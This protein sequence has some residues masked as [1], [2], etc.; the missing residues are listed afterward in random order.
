MIGIA[1]GIP[2]SGQALPQWTPAQRALYAWFRMDPEYVS[3][4]SGDVAALTDLSG[5]ARDLAQTTA[6][7]RLDYSASDA[8]FNNRPVL[9][10]TGA[11]SLVRSGSAW[12]LVQ[13][14]TVYV[15]WRSGATGDFR[16]AL[17]HV[18]NPRALVR[19]EPAG[20]AQTYAN[21]SILTSTES[22]TS[23]SIVCA[24][25]N[26]ASSAVYVNSLTASA[27]GNAGTAGITDPIV[28]G[29]FSSAFFLPATGAI[30][31]IPIASGADSAA[32]REQM[33]R[34]LSRRYNIAVVGL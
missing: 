2:G 33:M 30:A 12:S 7:S 1:T 14:F 19:A 34:Y 3:L 10:G 32:Q 15:V 16:T 21:G 8:G 31:E 24:V 28:G 9:V 20:L 13:P 11:G 25:F 18:T 22:V 26:G 17:D 6:P 5:N 4:V 23:P 29:G 27:S